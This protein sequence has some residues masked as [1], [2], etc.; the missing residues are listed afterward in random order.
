MSNDINKVIL[1]GRLT[2]DP[3]TKT[4]PNGTTVTRASIANGYTYKQ[5]TE[6]KEQTSYFDL[7]L[8]GKQGE[9]LAEYG[10]KGQQ[11]CIEGS[12]DQ[13]R[14][15]DSDGKN[16]SAVEI[17]VSNFQFLGGKKD[18]SEPAPKK[19]E[20]FDNPFADDDIAF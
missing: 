13:K 6:K 15:Q 2:R 12:L 14:W 5:G 20:G 19:D 9:I 7:T 17:T 18:D 10:K 8:W 3:E 11:L 1:I 16:R 4:T